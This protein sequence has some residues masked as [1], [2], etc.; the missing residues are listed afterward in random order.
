M[1]NFYVQVYFHVYVP[2]HLHVHAENLTCTNEHLDQH[3]C[4]MCTNCTCTFLIHAT[5]PCPCCIPMSILH[6]HVSYDL[7]HLCEQTAW[8][9][10]IGHAAR[11]W[12]I[13]HALLDIKH[14]H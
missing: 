4:R 9:W 5:S 1:S 7:Q 13:G 6:V 10:T 3:V 2:A 11:T 14:G 12:T 8:T